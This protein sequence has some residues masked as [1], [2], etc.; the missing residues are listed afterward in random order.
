MH[1]PYGDKEEIIPWKESF[2]LERRWN[3]TGSLCNR[4]YYHA[5]SGR[6]TI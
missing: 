3:I 2:N 4:R 5:W 1:I 6:N